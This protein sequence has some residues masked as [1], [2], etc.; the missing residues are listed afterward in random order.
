MIV[1][2]RFIACPTLYFNKI[3][4]DYTNS[5]S[6]LRSVLT[7][8]MSWGEHINKCAIKSS[9]RVNLLSRV[10]YKLPRFSLSSIYKTLV[11]PIIEYCNVIYDNC[12]MNESMELEKVQ[13][14]AAF[15]CTW[16]YR[17]TKTELLLAELGWQ[18]LTVRC[19]NHKLILLYKI[20]NGN[21]VTL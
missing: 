18:P 8:S 4:V 1:T 15:V 7:P 21:F 12:T 6:H 5:H 14:C 11:R 10:K 3:P 16:A 13:R 2:N 9:H 20:L 17:H 19:K